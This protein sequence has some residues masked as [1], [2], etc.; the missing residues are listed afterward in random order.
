MNYPN[1]LRGSWGFQL[2]NKDGL[3]RL[4]GFPLHRVMPWNANKPWSYSLS[5]G[6]RTAS[7]SPI[8]L[9]TTWL[10]LSFTA[11]RNVPTSGHVLFPELPIFLYQAYYRYLG[12]LFRKVGRVNNQYHYT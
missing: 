12:Y 5:T 3:I 11:G 4:L 8:A 10:G 2:G 6:E 9:R 7:H 1:L